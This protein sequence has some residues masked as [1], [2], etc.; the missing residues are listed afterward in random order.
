[1][2]AYEIK[3]DLVGD[4][5]EQLL[6]GKYSLYAF[7]AV[8]GPSGGT[9][10]VWFQTNNFLSKVSVQWSEVYG[11]YISNDQQLKPNVLIE[12]EQDFSPVDLNQTVTIT[13]SGGD[14]T[15]T[16]GGNPLGITI[17]NK[18]TTK[19]ITGI[20]QESTNG[21]VSAMCA[22]PLHGKGSDVIIPIE[23]VL[24]MFSQDPVNTGTVIEQA[25]SEGVLFNMTTV[26]G[27]P[28]SV[29]YDMDS[30]WDFGNQ[31]ICT[32]VGFQEDLIPLL[33]LPP[34]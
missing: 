28:V 14:G 19:F 12:A 4:T 23:Q 3:I 13:D 21:G 18:S 9:P 29:S 27:Q 20:M 25:F 6:E 8:T 11:A 22:F 24:L 31:P 10:L 15:V 17:E 34:S 32:N 7:K 26:P 33:V 30:G 1:M 5:A 16:T 2:A